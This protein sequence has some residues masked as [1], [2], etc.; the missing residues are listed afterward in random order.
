MTG[1]CGWF[2]GVRDSARKGFLVLFCKKELLAL[3][4]Y[5]RG[6]GPRGCPGLRPGMTGGWGW[7]GGVRDSADKGFLVLFCKKELLAL[8]F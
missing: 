7:F 3:S 1:E 8:S 4:F 6:V 5:G 2:G